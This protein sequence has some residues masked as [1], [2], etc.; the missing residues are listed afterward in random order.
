MTGYDVISAVRNGHPQEGW[1]VSRFRLIGAIT[2]LAAR[3]LL[4]LI[5]A[6]GAGI[7]L[8]NARSGNDHYML[9]I[10]ALLGVST[11]VVF[12]FWLTQLRNILSAG[13][14]MV[15]LTDDA[16]VISLR[17]KVTLIPFSDIENVSFV[18]LYRFSILPQQ[19]IE[20]TDKQGKFYEIAHST[21]FRG[22]ET[23]F[24]ELQAK[25]IANDTQQISSPT[26]Y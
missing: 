5:F 10:G 1:V 2:S 15:V 26:S 24:R 6:S 19:V 16:T 14:N 13:S 11:L 23:L 9:A 8:Y 18:R 20:C 22:I 25:G 17:G 4:L 7:L 3:S 12:F 21:T